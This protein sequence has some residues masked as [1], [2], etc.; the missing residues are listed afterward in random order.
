MA[1]TIVS[2]L[3]YLI[4]GDGVSTTVAIQL[5]YTPTS[6]SFVNAFNNNT[7]A[8]V[9][10]NIASVTASASIMT[11]NFNAA[12][13][14]LASVFVNVL[15]ALPVLTA[16]TTSV[17][18]GIKFTYRTASGTVASNVVTPAFTPFVGQIFQLKGSASKV[19]RVINF[20]IAGRCTTAGQVDFTVARRSTAATGGTAVTPNIDSADPVDP[21]ATSVATYWTAAPTVGTII[22]GPFQSVTISLPDGKTAVPPYI[23]DFG[24]EPGSKAFVLRGVNDYFT[25]S[26]ATITAAAP[27]ISFWCEFT[28]E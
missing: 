8:N 3:P 6:V 13:S 16:G 9:S 12:F 7:G 25:V 10:S 17:V 22:G 28:E 26:I 2:A 23:L 19:V 20:E 15:P 5:G 21:S 11:I 1:N 27:L 4:Q 24:D 18:D 14:Y